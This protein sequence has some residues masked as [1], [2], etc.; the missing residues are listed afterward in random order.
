[1]GTN[2][3]PQGLRRNKELRR[4]GE[5]PYPFLQGMGQS[6]Q[7][8]GAGNSLDDSS[9]VDREQRLGRRWNMQNVPS[10]WC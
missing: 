1:M 4:T 9:R 8:P 10:N 3:E 5:Y 2:E 7:I 6:V